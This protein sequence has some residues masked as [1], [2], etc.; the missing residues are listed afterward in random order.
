MTNERRRMIEA[1]GKYGQGHSLQ[2]VRRGLRAVVFV[3]CSLTLPHAFAEEDPSA[4]ET[5]AARTLALEGIKLADAGRCEEAIERLTR[6]ERLH[7]ALVVLGRLGECQVTRGRLVEGTEI[8]RR[9][10]RETLPP[11]PP[12]VLLKARERAQSV[13]D[14][15]KGKIGA[16]NIIVRGPED[17]ALVTVMVDGE[18][19]NVALLE[20]DRPTDPGEHLIEA[21][22][23]GFVGASS[24]VTVGAGSRHNVVIDL[25]LDPHALVPE[26]S[27]GAHVARPSE[28]PATGT[29]L[30]PERTAIDPGPAEDAATRQIEH[31]PNHT[32]AY[33][34]WA[35]GGAAVLTGSVLGVMALNRKTELS[36]ECPE[37]ICPASA[38]DR[39]DSARGIGTAATV[40]FVVAGAAAGLGTIL[41]FTVGSAPDGSEQNTAKRPSPD[42][43]DTTLRARAWIGV[44]R[45]GL[46]GEF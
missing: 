31:E 29:Q 37:N 7:H 1:A 33:I 23:P 45:V 41:Y 5:A 35:A 4:E 15:T 22:A 46:S 32:A 10:L 13:L 19:M 20:V 3:A 39:L 17:P 28:Q 25:A 42:R 9:V 16:V 14:R 38:S 34:A 27:S 11:S 26:P 8:L 21:S 12:E 40:S 43:A 6:A 44:G 36:D 30:S 2:K 24:H 18:P